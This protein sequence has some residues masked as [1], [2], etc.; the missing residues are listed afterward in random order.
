MARKESKV[1]HWLFLIGVVLAVFAALMPMLQTPKVVWIL[2]LLGLIVGVLN[3][4]ARETQEFLVAAVALVIG[5]SAGAQIVVLPKLLIGMLGNVIAFV[6]PAAVV[7][8]L[9]AIWS[10]ASEE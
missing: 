1:G 6:F 4:T 9:K 10:L 2:V 5:A 3:I 8:A 7:V